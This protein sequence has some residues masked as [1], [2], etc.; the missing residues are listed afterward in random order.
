M[1]N[2]SK[3]INTTIDPNK[4]ITTNIVILRLIVRHQCIWLTNT[5]SLCHHKFCTSSD[6]KFL[7]ISYQ[8]IQFSFPTN[9]GV[10]TQSATQ[11]KQMSFTALERDANATTKTSLSSIVMAQPLGSASNYLCIYTSNMHWLFSDLQRAEHCVGSDAEQEGNSP[12]QEALDDS[13]TESLSWQ[14]MIKRR[15]HMQRPYNQAIAHTS[16][17]YRQ[18]ASDSTPDVGSRYMHT[19][20]ASGF[21]LSTYL[22]LAFK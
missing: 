14:A 9:A 11:Q 7:C 6:V 21:L 18:W 1:F 10:C 8:F 13:E 12:L 22:R 17:T 3:W 16:T 2:T 20:T 15:N 4:V 19:N 5:R